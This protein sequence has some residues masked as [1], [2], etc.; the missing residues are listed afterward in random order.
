MRERLKWPDLAVQGHLQ[1]TVLT[2]NKTQHTAMLTTDV[3]YMYGLHT[4]THTS[5][6]PG[7]AAT[8]TIGAP[9]NLVLCNVLLIFLP[10]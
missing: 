8:G 2:V 9:E 7:L 6:P 4:H 1:A 10:I 5:G 3:S